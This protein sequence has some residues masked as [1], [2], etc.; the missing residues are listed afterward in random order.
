MQILIYSVFSYLIHIGN[1]FMIY[2]FAD[3]AEYDQSSI[4]SL[5]EMTYCEPK[6]YSDIVG[7]VEGPPFKVTPH[8]YVPLRSNGK[9]ET[10]TKLAIQAR[11]L[12]PLPEE[13]PKNKQHK[14]NQSDAL[15]LS[16][17][18]SNMYITPDYS[19]K[20]KSFNAKHPSCQK[21][22]TNP[23]YNNDI[24]RASIQPK[25]P[26]RVRHSKESS[27]IATPDRA[28]RP[29]EYRHTKDAVMNVESLSMNEVTEY[30]KV[31]NLGQYAETFKNNMID[32][33]MLIGLSE[34]ML[35]KDF[36]MNR[37]EV[38]R[39]LKFAKEGYIPT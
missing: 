30:L 31:L 2:V 21:T 16:A 11:P 32:G 3:I 13:I 29:F 35:R 17:K 26:N 22:E 7:L 25:I 1:E 9:P 19:D 4:H 24:P 5:T 36:G 10:N 15:E 28:V 34:K 20:N 12:P 23:Q 18:M 6:L 39:L 38:F 8:P 33:M 27:Q 37:V 14:S